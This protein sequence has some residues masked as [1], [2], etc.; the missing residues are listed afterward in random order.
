M[1]APPPPPRRSAALDADAALYAQLGLQP[2]ASD[3]DVRRAY[4]RLARACH[5][6][7][8]GPDE[9]EAAAADRFTRLH[10]AYQALTSTRKRSRLDADV[11]P[12]YVCVYLVRGAVVT[13]V[14]RDPAGRLPIVLMCLRTC[15]PEVRALSHPNTYEHELRALYSTLMLV[16]VTLHVYRVAGLDE[17]LGDQ[18]R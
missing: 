2:G 4:L 12:E 15:S 9:D 18:V 11:D 10:H 5:P 13:A 6:D 7:K 17:V 14:L 16:L 3:Q 1:D 8:A